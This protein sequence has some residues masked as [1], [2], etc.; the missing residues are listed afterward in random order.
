MGGYIR[1]TNTLMQRVLVFS[2]IIGQSDH[3]RDTRKPIRQ[4][5]FLLRFAAI[6]ARITTSG[7]PA[8]CN[9]ASVVVDVSKSHCDLLICCA[10]I[11]GE[12]P[13]ARLLRSLVACPRCARLTFERV[14]L[15][16]FSLLLT[17]EFY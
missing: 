17:H 11:F 1:L 15:L 4:A 16:P 12:R 6:M 9:S 3:D 10:T 2:R 5:C 14:T 8:G 7:T 13:E